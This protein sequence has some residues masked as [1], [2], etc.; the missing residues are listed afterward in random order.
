VD[1]GLSDGLGLSRPEGVVLTA[2]HRAS[3][4]AKAGMQ[5]G[6]VVVEVAGE[7]VNTPAEMLFRMS[8]QGLGRDVDMVYIR[9]GDRMATRVA[10]IAPPEDPPRDARMLAPEDVLAG[11]EVARIN[12]ALMSELGLPL[13]KDGVVVVDPGQLGRRVGL[14]AGDV[15]RQIGRFRIDAPEDVGRALRRTAPNVAIEAERGGQRLI[16]RFRA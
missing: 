4:L 8:V 11:M 3:P 1:A 14:Q 13:N 9:E 16:L 5:V 6:D 2:L 15:L 10:L 12:P 7:P